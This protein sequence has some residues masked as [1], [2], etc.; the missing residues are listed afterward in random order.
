MEH[1]EV[2]QLSEISGASHKGLRN[3]ISG[4]DGGDTVF[5]GDREDPDVAEAFTAD[6]GQPGVVV[7]S[8]QAS[9][10]LTADDLAAKIAWLKAENARLKVKFAPPGSLI[11]K[12]SEKR[13][14]SL[15]GLGRFPT[16]LYRDQ[17]EKLL[18]N[19]D[20]IRE[21]IAD[22]PDLK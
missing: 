8:V 22:H 21:F 2:V 4:P 20:A 7:T 15:Y 1:L 11:L 18:A 12:V 3:S 9:A 5:D 16:T 6:T 13:A 17:W 10:P 19:A 14:I